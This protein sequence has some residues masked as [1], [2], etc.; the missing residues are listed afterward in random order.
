[1]PLPSSAPCS[2]A[3]LQ[4]EGL[5]PTE[6]EQIVQRLGRRPNRTELGMF[7]VMWSEH[8]CYKNSRPLLKQFPTSGPRILVG[9]GENAGV[10]DLGHNQRLVF[11]I[12]SHNHPSAI[13]PFQGAAT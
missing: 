10:V 1:M 12:E 13:E 4:Q 3:D 11:K 5:S 8:C 7:G 9:P 6:Y 2:P